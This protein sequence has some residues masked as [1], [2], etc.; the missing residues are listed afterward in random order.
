MKKY[1]YSLMK[2]QRRSFVHALP[3]LLLYITSLFY[4]AI[5]KI[6]NFCYEKGV[7]KIHKVD[8]KIISVGN[9]T[10]G[11]TGKT[12]FAIFLAAL[13]KKQGRS[14][15]ILIRGYGDDEWRML[16]KNI[17]SVP[18]IKGRDR[19]ESAKEAKRIYNSEILILDDGFQHRRLK[20]DLDIVLIDAR[21]SFGNER[22]FPRGVLREPLSALKRADIIVLTKAD[23]GRDNIRN[24]RITLSGGFEKHKALEAVYKPMRFLGLRDGKRL[25]LEIAR[26]KKICVL[27]AIADSAY[28]KYML[29]NLGAGLTE[30]IDYPDHHN[31]TEKDLAY[32]EKKAQESG[33]EFIVT[34][35]KD[36]VKL[37][38][39]SYPLRGGSASLRTQLSATPILVLCI[40][41]E[42]TKGMEELIARLNRLYTG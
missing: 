36:A 15:A 18:V 41:L 34:T 3:K 10:L 40:E 13:L 33:C 2:N 14:V 7:F 42:I 22:I 6:W 25:G 24:L 4:I 35:E 38:A 28:F 31:Y 20:R 12:P 1:I 8:T 21:Q 5:I 19:V 29:K 27:S 30:I 11:G 16:E 26:N 9:I 39:I 17:P 32:V 37:S 23:F